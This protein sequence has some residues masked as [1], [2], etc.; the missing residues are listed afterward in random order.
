MSTSVQFN[1]TDINNVVYIS[2]NTTHD[3]APSRSISSFKIARR[4][5]E[6]LVSAF[7]GSKE[8][9]INGYIV[10]TS[11][12]DFE[13]K[14]DALKSL[15]AN[16]ASNLDILYNGITRRYIATAT[17][18]KINRDSDNIDWSPYSVKFLVPLGYGSDISEQKALEIDDIITTTSTWN[19]AFNGSY[20]PKARHHIIINSLSNADVVRIKNLTTGAYIDVDLN[21]F[22]SGGDYLDIDEKNQTVLKN[23]IDPLNYRGVF[24]SAAPGSSNIFELQLIGSSYIVDQQNLSNAG[25]GSLIWYNSAQTN[26]PV[27]AQSFVAGQSGHVKKMNLLIRQVGSIGG[28]ASFGI[29]SDNNGLPGVLLGG[30]FGIA[31]SSVPS[32]FA[33]YT[34]I[35]SSTPPYLV[36]GTKYWIVNNTVLYMSG[37]NSTNYFMWG[38]GSNAA[39]YPAGLAMAQK[40]VSSPLVYGCGDANNVSV[41]PYGVDSGVFDFNFQEYIGDG[42]APGWSITWEIFYTPNYL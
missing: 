37:G 22:S 38:H 5:G 17:E 30:S 19:V 40:N 29:Y 34:T 13:S 41:L 2:E 4:D 42:N 9:D 14:A 20:N 15:L 33:G 27:E 16:Q 18:V 32:S 23:G 7:W 10:G 6:K 36:A 8:I 31:M 24:P 39:D 12:A 28:T 25:S 21:G 11:Q 1:G 26:E 3:S 35:T